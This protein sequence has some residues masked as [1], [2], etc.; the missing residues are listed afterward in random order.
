[1]KNIFRDIE[2]NF[3]VRE[4]FAS[5]LLTGVFL[6][7]SFV[8]Y[9]RFSTTEIV[10]VWGGSHAVHISYYGFPFEM[11]GLLTPVG[12]VETEWARHAGGLLQILWG[13]LVLNFA[14]YFLLTFVIVY[15]SRKLR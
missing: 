9:T 11:I 2:D 15:L 3:E 7:L 4:L 1:M 14:L 5:L 8:G 12:S 6:F 10:D 13:G